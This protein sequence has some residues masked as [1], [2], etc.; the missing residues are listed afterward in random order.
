MRLP[1]EMDE[2][3][4]AEARGSKRSKGAVIVDL[5]EEALRCRMFPG[6][7]FR[8]EHPYRRPWVIG[9]GLDV[10]EVV[11]LLR[12][13]GSEKK[14]AD[15]F[16]ITAEQIRVALAYYERFPEEIDERIGENELSL[17]ELRRR[18]PHMEVIAAGE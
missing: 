9:T 10:W 2:L 14:V 5:A 7:A 13:L 6:I 11:W 17:D 8:G 15:A 18:Y 12:D 3:V 4:T 16:R 1:V